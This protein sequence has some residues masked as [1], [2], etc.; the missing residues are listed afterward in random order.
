MTDRWP[1]R[2]LHRDQSPR[3][4]DIYGHMNEEIG[5]IPTQVKEGGAGTTSQYLQDLDEDLRDGVRLECSIEDFNNALQR[6]E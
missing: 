2:R 6:K 5:S 4:L 3:S 1:G